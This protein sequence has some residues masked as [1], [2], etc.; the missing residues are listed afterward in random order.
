MVC[1]RNE[2]GTQLGVVC[3]FAGERLERE[4]PRVAR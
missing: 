2:S 4:A 3:Q 1:A